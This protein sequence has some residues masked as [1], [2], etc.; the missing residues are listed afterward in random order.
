MGE[1]IDFD[2]VQHNGMVCCNN[3]YVRTCTQVT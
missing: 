3:V 1:D 2:E